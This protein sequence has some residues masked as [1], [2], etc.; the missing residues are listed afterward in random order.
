MKSVNKVWHV[1]TGVA[2]VVGLNYFPDNETVV[3]CMLTKDN[4]PICYLDFISNTLKHQLRESYDVIVDVPYTRH[5]L[6][7]PDKPSH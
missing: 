3:K 6:V 5:D 4:Q 7:N 2:F 1:V